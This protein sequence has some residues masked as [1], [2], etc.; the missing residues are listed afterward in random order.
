MDGDAKI[1][2]YVLL[3]KGV[4]G[5]GAADLITKATADPAVFGFGELLDVPSIKEVGRQLVEKRMGMACRRP[6]PAHH[7]RPRPSCV[8]TP[9]APLP[10]SCKARTWAPISPFCNYSRTGRGPTTRV[11]G[12]PMALAWGFGNRGTGGRWL[13][14]AC[15]RACV[16]RK[17][18]TMHLSQAMAQQYEDFRARVFGWLVTATEGPWWQGR[19]ARA[20]AT[21]SHPT[22]QAVHAVPM[23]QQPPG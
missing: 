1:Q 7:V 21:P 5:R 3:A 4:R 19:V 11:S 16:H 20:A 12:F 13:R 22:Q 10:R 23:C 6:A 2:Q 17:L 14:T 15:L 18:G 9:R 8:P